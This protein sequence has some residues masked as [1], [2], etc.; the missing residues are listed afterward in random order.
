MRTLDVVRIASL[1]LLG[2]PLAAGAQ[3]HA[4]VANQSSNVVHVVRTSDGQ[5]L[6]SIPVGL[7][8][9]GIA[10]PSVGGF[11]LVANKG[12]N[13]VSRIDL[14]SSNVSATIPV[15][16]NP[17][18][19]AVTPDGTKAYVVQSTNCPAPPEPTP[20]PDPTPTPNPEPTPTPPCTVAVIDTASSSVVG[21]VTVGREP[22]A[23]AVS[24]SGGFAYV[25]NRADDTVSIIDT[26]TDTVIGT[27]SVGDTPE[28]IAAGFG[29]VYVTND[30]AN[31]VSVYRE[32]DFQPLVTIGVGAGPV[33]VA[34]SPDG[35]T[36]VVGN[37]LG[38][39]VS[40]IETGTETVIGTRAVGTNPTGVAI[41]PDSALAVV[42]NSTSGTVT[43]L[44]LDS[45]TPVRTVEV[46]GSPTAVAIEPAPHF[47]I[48][49]EATPFVAVAGGNVTY[50]ISYQ[51]LGSGPA[52]D[53]TVTQAFS[54][55]LTFGSATFGGTLVGAD[56]VWNLGT[57]APGTVGTLE[58]SF[59]VAGAPPLIDGD[60]LSTV[61]T[62]ADASGNSASDSLTI[63]TRVPGGLG[64][65][66]G[67]YNKKNAVKP[68]DAW[69]FKAQI[70]QL[71]TPF[72][73]TEDVTITWSTPNQV[74]TTFTI[75]AGAWKGRAG[76]NRYNFTG[77]DMLGP[78]SRVRANFALRGNGLW[79]LNVTAANVTLPIVEVPPVITITANV[80][81]D[82]YASTREFRVRKT[83]KPNTQRLSYRSVIAG[84]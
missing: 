2:A 56:V 57:V 78:G 23:V 34:V 49:H 19:V 75:P 62:I 15:P 70:P 60:D 32:I 17:T 24:P 33:A 1:C 38:A 36:A 14:A 48:E 77:R 79:R 52:L 3:P 68:R 25:T 13:S 26:T 81:P 39:S 18:A 69:R 11:A 63:G 16:G 7:A 22:F 9:T 50:T 43:I 80:G 83:S 66:Q 44:P 40:I 8:P 6:N 46:L 61:V 67:N 41:T 54:P 5:V 27:V 64:L 31:S 58:A 84:D 74:I 73:N 30:A 37:D 28:G 59:S 71:V 20:G 45:P 76:S 51:N 29:T 35:R 10:I 47:S 42:A 82:V 12:G 21:S 53:T 4:Y 65:I 55:L 72:G